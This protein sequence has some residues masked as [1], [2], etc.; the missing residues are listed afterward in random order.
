[1]GLIK[2]VRIGMS[3]D[4]KGLT[5]G[6]KTAEAQLG[7]FG[8]AAS[9]MKGVMAGLGG[10]F[11]VGEIAS[12]IKA[13]VGRAIDLEKAMTGLSKA[14]DLEGSG[15][16]SMK[17]ELFGL[18]TSLKGVKLDDILK[19]ATTGAKM[20]V[21]A[22]EL[23]GYTRGVAMLST[24]L[25]DIPADLVA[26]QI[27]TINTVFK[28]GTGGA[29]QLGSAIDKLA[30]S[31]LSSSAG[32]MDVTS[33]V[34][35]MAKALGLGAD[36][37]V[38]LAAALLDTGTAAE[39][40]AGSLTMLLGAL[41]RVENHKDFATVIGTSAEKFA[42]MVRTRP[43]E[44]IQSFLGALGK[45]DA[46]TQ[47]KALDLVGIT[48]DR[49]ASNIQKLT[50][51]VG[52]LSKYLGMASHEFA[53]QTQIQQS[54]KKTAEQ[55]SAAWDNFTN[56]LDV[57]KNSIGTTGLPVINSTLETMGTH[58]TQL[59][60]L[61]DQLKGRLEGMKVSKS[62]KDDMGK[63]PGLFELMIPPLGVL[64]A[65]LNALSPATTATAAT[66]AAGPKIPTPAK[67]T[68]Q[69]VTGFGGPSAAAMVAG[70]G[71]GSDVSKLFEARA[72][73]AKLNL[74]VTELEKSLRSEVATFGMTGAMADVYRLKLAGASD[75]QLR[76]ATTA[77]QMLTRMEAN[78]GVVDLTSKLHEQIATFGQVGAAAELYHLK[79]SGADEG[80]LKLA[81]SLSSQLE[82]MQ[83]AKAIFDE[84]RT[85]LEQ[86]QKQA[87]K[88]K[89]LRMSGAISYDTFKRGTIAARKDT[90]GDAASLPRFAGAMEVGSQEAYSSQLKF[91]SQGTR[92]EPIKDVLKENKEQ[93]TLQRQ[94]AGALT[95][96]KAPAAPARPFNFL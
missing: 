68:P 31:G 96:G 27:G 63:M 65:T 19:I 11:A 3:V 1:M 28:L 77:A 20:G 92:E 61:M 34:S 79:L 10:A 16:A 51:K 66:T 55:T 24:A 71:A 42:E 80:Q 7:Q 17:T 60:G 9:A 56:R 49:G 59:T 46:G 38:S 41:A 30:D 15:L 21:A 74:S 64:G 78:K 43:I 44:A 32:I 81:G 89:E 2:D 36:Q 48:A 14:T 33:R 37:T 72:A 93:T 23:V 53:H 70:S 88:L 58:V 8:K 95:R 52:D 87:L 4:S 25:D 26:E 86:F 18:A 39:A 35:G 54:Y 57:M 73:A 67:I 62:F 47:L 90:I 82:K 85:P 76:T 22:D 69:R 83:S 12:G 5:T 75:A 94:M 13:S 91:A 45:L 29:T 84:T 50:E 40:G 6:L